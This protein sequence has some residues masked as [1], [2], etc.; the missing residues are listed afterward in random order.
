MYARRDVAGGGNP[1]LS[2]IAG[3]GG[4]SLTQQETCTRL[5]HERVRALVKRMYEGWIFHREAV[6]E[7]RISA[8]GFSLISSPQISQY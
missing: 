2:L 4:D 5:F 3:I 6:R 7:F 8:E 1:E